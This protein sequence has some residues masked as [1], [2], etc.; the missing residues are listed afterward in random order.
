MNLA[1]VMSVLLLAV[2]IRDRRSR[3]GLGEERGQEV[4][5]Q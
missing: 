4:A 3:Q 2:R 1:D 5:A